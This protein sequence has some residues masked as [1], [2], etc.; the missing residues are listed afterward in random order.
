MF[1]MRDL[2]TIVIRLKGL[3]RTGMMRE[4]CEDCSTAAIDMVEWCAPDWTTSTTARLEQEA[5][6]W[7]SMA[8]VIIVGAEDDHE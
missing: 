4:D 5:E 2:V 8:V 6:V 7:S 1:I 3:M